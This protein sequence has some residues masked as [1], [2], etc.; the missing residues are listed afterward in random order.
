MLFLDCRPVDRVN[1]G[2]D[3]EVVPLELPCFEV[4]SVF[5][6][7]KLLSLADDLRTVVVAVLELLGKL[8]S[9]SSFVVK[10]FLQLELICLVV[11]FH[12]SYH[13]LHHRHLHREPVRSCLIDAFW[14]GKLRH[15]LLPVSAVLKS[16]I[17]SDVVLGVFFVVEVEPDVV[18]VHCCHLDR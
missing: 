5:V 11:A 6:E 9:F 16:V 4:F 12:L 8:L 2:R 14:N 13:V 18:F 17:V 15:L 7:I 1:V 10:S 3:E